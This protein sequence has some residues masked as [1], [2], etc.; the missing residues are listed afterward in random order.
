MNGE[1]TD[2][3]DQNSGPLSDDESVSLFIE[4]PTRLVG[5]VVESGSQT[6]GPRETPD[7]QWM[8]TTLRPTTNHNICITMLDESRCITNAVC[9]RRACRGDG[10]IGTLEVI[11]KRDV[12][13]AEVDEEL[14]HEERVDF[15]VGGGGGVVVGEGC[16]VKSREIAYAAA[17]GDALNGDNEVSQQAEW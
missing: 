4:R 7:S 6:P 3:K 2:L 10:V 16:V 5:R 15:A 13:G 12:A 14:G 11:P 9:S 1:Y 17:E 8:N